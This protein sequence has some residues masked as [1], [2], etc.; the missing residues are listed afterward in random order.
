M[1]WVKKLFK[2]NERSQERQFLPFKIKLIKIILTNIYALFAHPKD[3][4]I[5]II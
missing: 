1:S 4:H 5:M 2:K 3:S